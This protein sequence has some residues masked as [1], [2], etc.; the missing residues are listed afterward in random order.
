MGGNLMHKSSLVKT[1]VKLEVQKRDTWHPKTSTSVGTAVVPAPKLPSEI[2]GK[3][4]EEIIKEWNVELQEKTGK[5]RKQ[6]NALADWDKINKTN[7]QKLLKLLRPNQTMSASLNL[8]RLISKGLTSLYN[9]WKKKLSEYTKM[10]MTYFL[11]MKQLQPEMQCM[12][13]LN[14]QREKWNK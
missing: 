13:K 11:M 9:V 10:N 6:A 7:R 1:R 12:S 8:S 14:S 4:V 3:T 2:T 5:F